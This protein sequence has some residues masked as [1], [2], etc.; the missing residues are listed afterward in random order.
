MKKC[1]SVLGEPDWAWM[2]WTAFQFE[3][4]LWARF[5]FNRSSWKTGRKQWNGHNRLIFPILSRVT[6]FA[7]LFFLGGMR[8]PKKSHL[9]QKH[10]PRVRGINKEKVRESQKD[11]S[12]HQKAFFFSTQSDKK[13]TS[14]LLQKPI[15]RLQKKSCILTISKPEN[16]K[17]NA[18]KK[19]RQQ[20]KSSF[21]QKRRRF[22]WGG[23]FD[24]K[25]RSLESGFFGAS[26]F[27]RRKV[28]LF[29]GTLVKIRLRS[30]G[31]KRNVLLGPCPSSETLAGLGHKEI[32]VFGLV[33]NIPPLIRNPPENISSVLLYTVLHG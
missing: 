28:F 32:F 20:R 2:N 3:K 22:F 19:N 10:E 5:F 17:K 9:K 27:Y 8:T 16:D 1:S 12:N 26:L 14:T 29:N 24:R 31:E 30:A 11:V 6:S 23:F 13:N 4:A 15:E 7:V 33:V 25:A 21:Q 18:W